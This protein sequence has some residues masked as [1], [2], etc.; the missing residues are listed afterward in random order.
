MNKVREQLVENLNIKP[1]DENTLEFWEKF[2]HSSL[3][4][5]VEQ[6]TAIIIDTHQIIRTAASCM[7]TPDGTMQYV[8]GVFDKNGHPYCL[9]CGEQDKSIYSPKQLISMFPEQSLSLLRFF[10]DHEGVVGLRLSY[11]D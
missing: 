10:N 11:D 8:I 3:Q 9:Q 7:G 2:I 1:D 4:V 6:S 5:L